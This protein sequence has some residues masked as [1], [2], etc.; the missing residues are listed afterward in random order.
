MTAAGANTALRLI[1]DAR[2]CCSEAASQH[3]KLDSSRLAMPVVSHLVIRRLP[4]PLLASVLD[5]MPRNT[6][7]AVGSIVSR[8]WFICSGTVWITFVISLWSP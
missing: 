8:L 4:A 6:Q 5:T 2:V 3:H 7:V 1:V